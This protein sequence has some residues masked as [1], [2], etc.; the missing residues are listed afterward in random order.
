MTSN[1]KTWIVDIGSSK[2]SCCYDEGGNVSAAIRRLSTSGAESARTILGRLGVRVSTSPHAATKAKRIV[3]IVDRGHIV[4]KDSMSRLLGRAYDGERRGGRALIAIPT[5][6]AIEDRTWL[7]DHH[8]EKR[9]FERVALENQCVLSVYPTGS[10]TGV[11]LNVGHGLS[12]VVPLFDGRPISKGVSVVSRGGKDVDDFTRRLLLREGCSFAPA[13]DRKIVRKIKETCGVVAKTFEIEMK[14][15]ATT[16]SSIE[17]AD[18]KL[19]DGSVLSV[20]AVSRWMVPEML[21][22]PTLAENDIRGPGVHIALYDALRTCPIDTVSR[23]ASNIVV[24]GG[25]T[26]FEGFSTRLE[27]EV[28]KRLRGATQKALNVASVDASATAGAR[29]FVRSGANESRWFSKASFEEH[30]SARLIR[31]RGLL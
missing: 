11:A 8:F 15:A 28:R 25:C 22:R 13:L 10:T 23:I 7:M 26:K 31:L 29:M 12:Q 2:V 21:F 20:S 4:D 5:R 24:G 1:V 9:G 19:P 18:F 6:G 16:G 14:R 27:G 17:D 3:D 30:G